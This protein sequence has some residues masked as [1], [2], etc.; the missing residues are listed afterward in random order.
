MLDD[1]WGAGS[2]L[3]VNSSEVSEKAELIKATVEQLRKP[4]GHEDPWVDL[5]LLMADAEEEEEE[6]TT[7]AQLLANVRDVNDTKKTG[8]ALIH[9]TIVYN[10]APYIELLHNQCYSL[11]LDLNIYDKKVGLTPLMWCFQLMRA[12]CCIELFSFIDELNFDLTSKDGT[13]TWDFVVPGSSFEEFLDQNN[14]FQY[15]LTA[16]PS[17]LD[18]NTTFESAHLQQDD[19]FDKLNLQLAG[20]TVDAE[21]AF[22][23]DDNDTS[24]AKNIIKFSKFLED[25]EFDKLLKDQYLEFSDYDIPQILDLL[26][27]LPEKYA[28]ITTYPAALIFQCVRYADHKLN[29][30]PLVESLIHLSLTRIIA[31]ASNDLTIDTETTGDIVIQSYWLSA[32]SFLYYYFCR[33]DLFFKRYATVLQDIVNTIRA[34]MIEITS[35]IHARLLPLIE[36]TILAYTT[37]DVVRQ[38]LY[39]KDWNFFKKRKQT[40]H[41]LLEKEKK[42]ETLPYYNSTMLKHLYPPSLEEQM[43]LSPMKVVQIFGALAYVLELHQSHQLFQQQCLSLSVEW[44][45]ST[46]FN[47]ILKNKRKKTLSRAHAVQIRL[48]LSSLEAWIKNNDLVVPKPNLVDDFMWQRFPYTLVCA[49]GDI[50]FSDPPVKNVATFK[51]VKT[52]VQSQEV[53]IVYDN[54]NSL[55]YYQPFHRIA[56]IHFERVFELLQWLQVATTLT[57]DD[58]L[59]ATMELLPCLTPQQLLKVTDKYNYETEEPKFSSTLRKKLSTM[60]KAQTMRNDPY[61]VEQPK[62]LLALPT[63]AELTDTYTRSIDSRS[64][65]PL[66]PIEIQDIVD[67]LHDENTRL[68]KNHSYSS[69][70]LGE[71][72]QDND[73]VDD[74]TDDKDRG[75]QSQYSGMVSDSYHTDVGDLQ[76]ADEYFKEL[77]APLATAQKPQWN[78]EEIEANPW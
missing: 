63:V 70:K 60:V 23:N 48:N 58:S 21:N 4:D 62:S 7:F 50:N 25:F 75:K 8:V 30:K 41:D 29:S 69:E 28:H 16:K 40:K 27:S 74:D 72:E 54:T 19:D 73:S 42:K 6:L 64:F 2:K 17:E 38:T 44:F 78:N 22:F 33:D 68:R 51:P 36:P 52:N 39:K 76:T 45:S 18:S 61:L 26:I 77:D 24:G 35:S 57:N 66:L 59:D 55:F 9:Y 1:V 14:I 10:H 71:E 20:M 56:H 5:V 46:L 32:V 47:K 49:L 37:I 43:K 15:K 67:E 11:D 12:N 53:P 34:L 13:N 31:A 3:P 65:Q